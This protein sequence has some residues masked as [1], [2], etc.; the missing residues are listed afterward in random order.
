MLQVIFGDD[1]HTA[2][3]GPYARLMKTRKWLYIVAVA[4][5][6]IANGL[7]NEK[8]TADLLK[9]ASI[10]TSALESALLFGLSYMLLQYAFLTW[11]LFTT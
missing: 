7:Y 10:P 2:A 9:V 8:A 11:Q 6:A 3:D 1:E 4:E 5:L